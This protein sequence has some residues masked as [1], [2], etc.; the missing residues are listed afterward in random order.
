LISNSANS[1]TTFQNRAATLEI[2][3]HFLEI[4]QQLL[5]KKKALQFLARLFLF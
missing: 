5:K 2:H 4:G 3:R 1:L